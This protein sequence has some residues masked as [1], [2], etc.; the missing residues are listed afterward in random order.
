MRSRQWETGQVVI[1]ATASATRRMAGKACGA[2]IGVS[3]NTLMFFV[4]ISLV[5]FMA[6]NTRKL[7]EIVLIQVAFRTS[8]PFALMCAGIYWEM[9]LIMIS[10]VGWVPIR[11]GG[12]ARS[13]ID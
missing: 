8:I 10:E 12:M 1:Y 5:V 4:C 6:V 9:H 7:C 13:T 3:I 2:A 11:I